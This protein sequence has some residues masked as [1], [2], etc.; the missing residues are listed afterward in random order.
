MKDKYKLL[1]K[2][3]ISILDKR[4]SLGDR[5]STSDGF[6][7]KVTAGEKGMWLVKFDAPLHIL[8]KFKKKQSEWYAPGDIE[9]LEGENK[10]YNEAII[11]VAAVM[12]MTLDVFPHKK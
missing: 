6:T 7:G 1:A 11:L 12:A 10:G 9:V 8:D 4:F 5:I 3:L 2:E